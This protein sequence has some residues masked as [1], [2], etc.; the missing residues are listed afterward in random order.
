MKR[1]VE[2]WDGS[3]GI[4]A[5]CLNGLRYQR[6]SPTSAM[7]LA[8]ITSIL[9]VRKYPSE[10]C[11]SFKNYAQ[12][13]K[14]GAVYAFAGQDYAAGLVSDPIVKRETHT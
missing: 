13:M 8:Q 14:A 5:P 4:N 6:L 10:G 7:A 3:E 1:R 9:D 11:N 2:V 12:E